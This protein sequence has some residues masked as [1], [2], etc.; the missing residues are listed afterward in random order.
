MVQTLQALELP[1]NRPSVW[2]LRKNTN[3]RMNNETLLSGVF[4]YVGTYFKR[5][6]KLI[7]GDPSSDRTVNS[8]YK[9]S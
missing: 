3:N 6:I 5:Y 4:S 8:W 1:G 7:T 9:K 2:F